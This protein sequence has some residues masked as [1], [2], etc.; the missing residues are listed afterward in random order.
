[1]GVLMGDGGRQEPVLDKNCINSRSVDRE[2]PV[3]AIN[4]RVLLAGPDPR[5]TLWPAA[6]A[7]CNERPE[8]MTA[9]DLRGIVRFLLHRGRL[10]QRP[11]SPHRG[12]PRIKA[13]LDANANKHR[14]GTS[15]QALYRLNRPIR[16]P[17][18]R[19]RLHNWQ[20]IAGCRA[21]RGVARLRQQ[22]RR[23]NPGLCFVLA[24]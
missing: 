24:E 18:Y 3:L 13:G 22:H 14:S 2:K 4:E 7:S 6:T 8:Y 11:Q 10:P 23:S 5:I 9:P 15:R 1:M 17:R 19:N 21:S 16:L 12:Q 20:S